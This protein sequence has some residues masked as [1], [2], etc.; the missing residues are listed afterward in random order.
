VKSER[1]LNIVRQQLHV[2]RLGEAAQR[3]FRRRVGRE[4][5]RKPVQPGN[6][7]MHE[8]SSLTQ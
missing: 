4:A 3:E 6:Q 5:A 2:Q 1:H 7:R 8:S